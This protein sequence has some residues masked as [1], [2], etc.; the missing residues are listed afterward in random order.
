MERLFRPRLVVPTRYAGRWADRGSAEISPGGELV[1]VSLVTDERGLGEIFEGMTADSAAWLREHPE[2]P[3]ILSVARYELEPKGENDYL[4]LAVSLGYFT[5]AY[6]R[7][8]GHRPFVDCEDLEIGV[9]AERRVRLGD[10]GARPFAERV[11]EALWHVRTRYGDGR[12]QDSTRMQ[13][14]RQGQG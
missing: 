13:L 8:T 12:V 4:H 2:A 5:D 11:S 1:L 6:R 9:S 3:P 14:Q 10:T 7:A